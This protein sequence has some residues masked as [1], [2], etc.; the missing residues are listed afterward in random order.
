[1][2]KESAIRQWF[3]N[4]VRMGIAAIMLYTAFQVF[5]DIMS[6]KATSFFGVTFGAVFFVYP[7]TFTFRDMIHKT[8]GKG[9]A[10]VV[11]ITAVSINLLMVLIFEVYLRMP[12]VATDEFQVMVHEASEL[13]YGSIWRIV[14][15][16]M[17]A[18]FVSQMI[19]TELYSV[20]V[21]RFGERHQ[22]GRVLFSNAIA[23]PIDVVI[24]NLIAFV[25]LWGN[26]LILTVTKTEIV[27]RLVMSVISIPLIYLQ[28]KPS[29]QMAKSLL[30]LGIDVKEGTVD[31]GEK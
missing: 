14:L 23:A 26:D 7:L 15:A 8:F 13:I 4:P 10:R 3:T 1:M 25:G 28:P 27:I 17:V 21:R 24:F 16:S 12:V 6:L 19:D 5:A 20:W 9:I 31:L 2:K 29:L 11:I 18:E 30:G 22:W